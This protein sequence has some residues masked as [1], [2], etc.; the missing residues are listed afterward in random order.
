MMTRISVSSGEITITVKYYY[1]R[2][3]NSNLRS[4]SYVPLV[5]F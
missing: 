4:H 1:E 2:V 5:S 3:K